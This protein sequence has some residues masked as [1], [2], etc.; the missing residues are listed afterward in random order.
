MPSKAT[1]TFESVS[2]FWDFSE[3]HLLAGFLMTRD[4]AGPCPHDYR[5]F[6]VGVEES[7]QIIL[8]RWPYGR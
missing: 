3:S 8:C 6:R 4:P 5:A 7:I 1:T 2:A